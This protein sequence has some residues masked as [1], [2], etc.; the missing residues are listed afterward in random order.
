M[1]YV[2]LANNRVGLEVLRWLIAQGDRPAG[3]VIHPADR[4]VCRE[5]LIAVTPIGV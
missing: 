4:G 5:E 1:R 3:L 2:Y